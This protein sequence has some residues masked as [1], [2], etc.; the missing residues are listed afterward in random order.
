MKDV[1]LEGAENPGCVI[2]ELE[3]VLGGWSQFISNN[4]E[5]EL[6]MGGRVFYR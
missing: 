1:L 2:L 5:R 3:I 6:V 4:I